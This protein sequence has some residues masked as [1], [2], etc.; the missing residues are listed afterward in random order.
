MTRNWWTLTS[1]VAG[2]EIRDRTRARSFWIATVI[3]VLAAA[4]GAIIPA[5]ANRGHSSQR[6]GI[7][8]TPAAAL[9]Q[10]AREAGRLSGTTVTVVTLPDVAAAKAQLRAGSLAAVLIG[11]SQVL[12][13]QQAV[14]GT[15]SPGATLAGVLAQI[16][17]LQ[18]L[19]AQLPPAAAARLARQG[20][21]LPV[22]WLTPPPRGLASRLTGLAVAILI[23]VIILTYG[24]RITIG[25]GE[26]KASRVV[27]VLLTTLRPVQLLAGKVIGMGILAVAQAAAAPG[28]QIRPVAGC[29]LPR[30]SRAAAVPPRTRASCAAS[31]PP[32]SR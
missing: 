10:T 19:Y 29:P 17:G 4:A 13:K 8:G 5:L 20:I 3:L 11:D 27:E 25:V 15:G 2:R 1:L 16:G 24:V 26:E 12:V 9:A 6:V 23:Y 7:V 18:R 22:H 21:A 32:S 30:P 31:S 14:A 28:A